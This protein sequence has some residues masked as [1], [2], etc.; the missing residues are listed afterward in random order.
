MNVGNYYLP[1]VFNISP[2]SNQLLCQGL[3][4]FF[5]IP[6]GV[7]KEVTIISLNQVAVGMV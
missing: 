7:N 4:G 2:R 1:D 5:G 6:A 3:K